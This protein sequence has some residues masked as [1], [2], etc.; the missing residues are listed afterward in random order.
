[1]MDKPKIMHYIYDICTGGAETLVKNYMLNFNKRKF[2]VVLLCMKHRQGSPYEKELL[3]NNIRVIYVEDYLFS[4]YR[5]NIFVRFVNH[6]LQYM[7]VKK[8]IKRENPNVLHTHLAL[9]AFVRFAKP[10]RSTVIIHT[11]HNEPRK[12]WT[13]ERRV[14]RRD[15]R[16]AKWLV[17]HRDMKFI[18][19]HEAMR[20]EINKMFGVSDSIVLNNG[21]E[22]AKFNGLVGERLL[23]DELCIPQEAF[24]VGHVGRF[25]PQKNHV[26]LVNVFN[27]IKK[28]KE[29]AFLLMVG[30]G[31]DREIIERKLDEYGLSR[32]YLVLS[33]RSDIPNLLSVMDIFVFPSLFE[34]LPVSLI[35]AQESRLPC[36]IS[37]NISDYAIMSNLVSSFSLKDGERK[38]AENILTYKKPIK[39]IINDSDWDIRKVTKKLEKL[40][41]DFLAERGYGKK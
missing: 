5:K 22:V 26:F 21:I 34:G 3:E 40:Y 39:T 2:E 35:E 36:F 33:N 25:S 37:D 23:R 11:A 8:I 9:N 20:L 29:N 15:L 24:V 12:L 1:M 4:R 27:E 31:P 18:A 10:G 28:H 41:L 17:K 32:S 16:A 30:E 38:W 13:S 14:R 7:I 6:Y 19:L